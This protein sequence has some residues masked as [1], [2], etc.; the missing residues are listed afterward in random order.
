MHEVHL[1]LREKMFLSGQLRKVCGK[2]V[3]FNLDVYT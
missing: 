3:F 2:G 1:E